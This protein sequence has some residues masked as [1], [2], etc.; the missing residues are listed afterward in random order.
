MSAQQTASTL[1]IEASPRA[2]QEALLRTW[3]EPQ[4]EAHR[5]WTASLPAALLTRAAHVP[6]ASRALT[7]WLRERVPLR[8]LHTLDGSAAV[9][10]ALGS[11]REIYRTADE[12]GWLLMRRWIARA[13]S[14]RDVQS[15]IDFLGRDRYAAALGPGPEFWRDTAAM[16]NPAYQTPHEQLQQVFR[17]LGFQS[18]NAA[19]AGRLEP[20]R[21]RMRLLAGP[22]AAPAEVLLPLHLDALLLHLS[23]DAP[24]S[25]AAA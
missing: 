3:S 9:P 21:G 13:V 11:A 18:L 24:S 10:W 23:G 8:P 14:R 19:L 6:A 5:G 1:A 17:G 7:R 15:L 25:A 22:Q 12:A 16:P 4:R 2:V 20:F